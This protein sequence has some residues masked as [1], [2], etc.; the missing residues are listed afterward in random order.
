MPITS[1]CYSILGYLGCLNRRHIAYTS[2]GGARF[3]PN[4]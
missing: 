3:S 2:V 1:P 4:T